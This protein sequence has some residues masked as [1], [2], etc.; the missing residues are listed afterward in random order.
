MPEDI[1]TGRDFLPELTFAASRSR[2][3]GGQHVNKVSTKVELRFRVMDSVL[4][5][6]EEKIL[7]MEKLATR[8]NQDGELVLTS[9]RERT[10]LKN[11]QTVIAKFLELLRMALTPR[12]RRKPTRPSAATKE[13]RLVDKKI[14]SEKKERRKPL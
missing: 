1:L 11:K 8:I 3:P 13:K 9:Q 7:V 5:T 6:G 14:H 10:Q 12:K 4:L 2:G